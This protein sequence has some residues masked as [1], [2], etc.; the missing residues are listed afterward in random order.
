ML[1]GEY[2]VLDGADAWCAAVN[3][4][5]AVRDDGDAPFTPPEA[6]AAWTEAATD[7]LLR[8]VPA[9]G[10]A[11]FDPSGLAD[12]GRKLGLGSSAALCVAGLAWAVAREHG[13]ASVDPHRDAIALFARRGHRAAQGGGSG[14]DVLASAYGG[15]VRVGFEDGVPQVTRHALPAGLRWRTY[16]SGTPVRTPARITAVR[17]LQARDAGIYGACMAAV[18]AATESFGDALLRADAADLVRAVDCLGIALDDLGTA[19]GVPV[20]TPSM[21]RLAE[22][23]RSHGAAVKPS[24]AGGG[25]VVLAFATNDGALDALA[26]VASADGLVAVD[27]AVDDAGVSVREPGPVEPA[28]R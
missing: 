1:A 20:V 18:R 23:A 15:V 27:L 9:D 24:G 5:V 13:A 25:D 2:A 7:G 11:F 8:A 26:A 17:A 12:H 22:A 6:R 14:V 21:R 19:A 28:A 10:A 16:W 4:R 3:R